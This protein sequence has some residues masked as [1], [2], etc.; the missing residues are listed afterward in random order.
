MRSLYFDIFID[1]IPKEE[2]YSEKFKNYY[3]RISLRQED[4]LDFDR[5]KITKNYHFFRNH[6]DYTDQKISRKHLK[7]YFAVFYNYG[8]VYKIWFNFFTSQKRDIQEKKLEEVQDLNGFDDNILKAFHR[9]SDLH[10]V[11]LCPPTDRSWG[12]RRNAR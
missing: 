11:I 5:L 1:I 7:D 2:E 10:R 12:R 4:W 3:C 9:A 6:K 8:T